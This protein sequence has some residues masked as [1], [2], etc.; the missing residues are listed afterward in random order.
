MVQLSQLNAKRLYMIKGNVSFNNIGNIDHVDID[1]KPLTVFVG[2]NNTGKTLLINA[3]FFLHTKKMDDIIKKMVKDLSTKYPGK[4]FPRAK[5]IIK[6]TFEQLNA[7]HFYSEIYGSKKFPNSSLSFQVKDYKN[8]E[9][10]IDLQN[11]F[12]TFFEETPVLLDIIKSVSILKG[13]KK[14]PSIF[15]IDPED[16]IPKKNEKIMKLLETFNLSNSD[17][18]SIIAQSF[19]SNYFCTKKNVYMFPVERA[20]INTFLFDVGREINSY[21]VSLQNYLELINDLKDIPE[22]HKSEYF[23]IACELERNLFNGIIDIKGSRHSKKVFFTDVNGKD[24]EDTIFS[25]SINELSTFILYLKF[26]AKKGDMVFF[27]EPEIS[28]H[29]DSQRILIRYISILNNLGIK[30]QK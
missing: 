12:D 9:K 23:N 18:S 6:D 11:I 24:V 8:I 16:D 4:P 7:Y 27:D 22:D 15:D 25:S 19:F 21:N 2:K 5:R 28:L 1:L 26:K 3:L 10:E 30:L 29:P 13:T 17:I 14:M 20:G